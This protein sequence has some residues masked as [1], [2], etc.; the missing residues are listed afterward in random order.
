MQLAAALCVIGGIPTEDAKAMGEEGVL[1]LF[2]FDHY[3]LAKEHG[4]PDAHW[5]LYPRFIKDHR[6]KTTKD[7]KFSAKLRRVTTQQEDFRR[8]MLAKAG[9]ADPPPKHQSRIKSAGFDKRW[10]KKMNGNVIPRISR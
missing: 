3:P 6:K 2:E 9:Q 10:R 7:Q 5:N 1:S 8:R 4:G